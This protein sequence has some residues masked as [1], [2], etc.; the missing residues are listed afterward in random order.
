MAG[1]DIKNITSN[2]SECHTK[3]QVA[4]QDMIGQTISH[5]KILQRLGSG[6]MGIV[7]KAEDTRLKRSVALKFLPPEFASDPDAKTRFIHEAQAASVLEHQNICTIHEID[8]TADHQIFICM[9][10]YEGETLK[11]RIKQEDFSQNEAYKISLQITHGLMQAHAAGVI[12]RDLKPAN[13]MITQSDEVRILDFGLAKF[14]GQTTLT[15]P[16]TMPGTIP[17]MSPEQIKGTKVDFRTDIWSFGIILYEMYCGELPFKGE[18]DQAV[19]YS[20][21]NEE[22]TPLSVLDKNVPEKLEHIIKRCL[23]KDPNDRFQNIVELQSELEV[24][25]PQ[26][27]TEIRTKPLFNRI[28]FR[29][30]AL[31]AFIFLI[32]I[33]IILIV[34]SNWTALKKFVG[35]QALPQDKHLAILPITTPANGALLQP[36]LDGL[37][38]II[39][40]RLTQVEKLNGKIWIVPFNEICKENISSVVD[41]RKKF[42]VNLAI[43]AHCLSEENR[44][45][46]IFNLVDTK[47]LRQIRSGIVEGK[48]SE[49]LALQKKTVNMLYEML[50][51]KKDHATDESWLDEQKLDPTAYDFYIRGLGYLQKSDIPEN[52]NSAIDLLR[53]SLEVD[54][55]FPLAHAKLGE[56]YWQKY[57]NSKD[58][59]WVQFAKSHCKEALHIDSDIPAALVTE[60]YILSG[61]GKAEDAIHSF[62]RALVLDSSYADAYRGLARALESKGLFEA[63]ERTYFKSIQLQPAYWKNYNSLGVFFYRQGRYRNAVSQFQKVIDLTPESSKG[64]YNLGGIYFFLGDWE[65]AEKIYQK[66]VEIDPTEVGHSNLGTLN[67]YLKNYKKSALMYEKALAISDNDYQIWAGLAEA[68][69]WQKNQEEKFRQC[70]QKAISLSKEQL[71]INPGNLE[72]MGDLA[73]YHASLGNVEQAQKLLQV[74]IRKKPDNVETYFRIGEVFEILG[75]RKEALKWIEKSLKEGFSIALIEAYPGLKSLR[76]DSQYQQLIN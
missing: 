35:F 31:A 63:A 21:L 16:N 53:K 76:E 68:Y 74:L 15:K 56:A 67:F 51:I 18:Y 64:Y 36:Y 19:L 47:K 55:Q 29:S 28:S 6:G 65:E 38:E 2:I 17:Y 44:V 22:P 41:A 59:Q 33:F 54:P 34:S 3:S 13:I 8:E 27:R 70:Y 50:E 5:Y 39:S 58:I 25:S 26:L 9:A 37:V 52:L 75:D 62:E 42:G 23:S 49:D 1:F 4:L 48:V 72:I 7:Y 10:Y 40:S 20:I 46:L 12:H 60:G 71:K 32:S 14:A 61:T 73:G 24:K 69:R 11:E 45:Q 57:Q 66:S 43:T 30:W